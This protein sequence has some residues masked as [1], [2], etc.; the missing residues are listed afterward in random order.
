MKLV[1][2]SPLNQAEQE[3]QRCRESDPVLALPRYQSEGVVQIELASN[4]DPHGFVH[5]I[6]EYLKEMEPEHEGTV[7]DAWILNKDLS[8]SKMGKAQEQ[9]L[10]IRVQASFNLADFFAIAQAASDLKKKYLE[11]VNSSGGSGKV[12]TVVPASYKMA[13]WL[14]FV[15]PEDSMEKILVLI[16]ALKN[17]MV[18]EGT[19]EIDWDE[20]YAFEEPVRMIKVRAESEAIPHL[21]KILKENSPI[22]F[23]GKIVK[24]IL[25]GEDVDSPFYRDVLLEHEKQVNGRRLLRIDNVPKWF[26]PE[27]AMVMQNGQWLIYYKA[28]HRKD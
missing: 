1:I 11:L 8:E 22:K 21:K 23:G 5:S 25:K 10:R 17:S 20:N 24:P 19:Y 28:C 6:K 27:K 13:A 2:C 12:L 7:V 14:P 18:K 15:T 16:R 3:Y 26:K 4:T 9:T